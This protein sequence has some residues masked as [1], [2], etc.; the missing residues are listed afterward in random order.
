MNFE[1]ARI[2][3]MAAVLDT[4]PSNSVSPGITAPV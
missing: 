2:D 4:L 1:V 3:P